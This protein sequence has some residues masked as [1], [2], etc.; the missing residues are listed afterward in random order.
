MD[1]LL[2]W[3][4]F[5]TIWDEFS[6]VRNRPILSNITSHGRRTWLSILYSAEHDYTYCQCTLPHLH[7][8][9]QKLGGC[10]F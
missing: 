10:T 7:I 4:L 8:Y 5:V 9:L 1:F 6:M 2:F 3:D